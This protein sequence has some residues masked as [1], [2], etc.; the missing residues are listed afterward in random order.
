[1]RGPAGRA[2]PCVE[3]VDDAG[4]ADARRTRGLHVGPAVAGVRP[5]V[6]LRLRLARRTQSSGSCSRIR[7][8]WTSL[9]DSSS[10]QRVRSSG[11]RA[12]GASMYGKTGASAS[13]SLAT[14]NHVLHGSPVTPDA[15]GLVASSPRH[16]RP[17]RP[18]S[19]FAQTLPFFA[20]TPHSL[21]RPPPLFGQ[22]PHSLART[23][24][25]LPRPPQSLPRPP[26]SLPR[27]PS[28]SFHLNWCVSTARDPR[29]CR[30]PCV[31]RK[32]RKE[33]GFWPNFWAKNGG[34]GHRVKKWAQS[35]FCSVISLGKDFLIMKSC[36]P[37]LLS[38]GYLKSCTHFKTT[39]T[40]F[41][42]QIPESVFG[43]RQK[44]RSVSDTGTKGQV[45]ALSP[46]KD[47]RD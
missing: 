26:H 11:S 4:G 3:Q 44:K 14:V 8:I 33:W 1:M 7:V 6:S 25:S 36:C 31:R 29:S 20:R 18:P 16:A 13:A 47:Q 37:G 27:P 12:A 30:R 43:I 34:S 5:R 21:P 24:Q 32:L 42:I 45:L 19:L 41:E 17:C 22:T 39:S 9:T 10:L 40:G 15:T 23:P 35:A 38:E 28:I 46:C 2:H